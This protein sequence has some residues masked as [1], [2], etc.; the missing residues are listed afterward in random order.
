MGVQIHFVQSRCFLLPPC[1]M[2]W[3]IAISGNIILW[4][5][6]STLI[7]EGRFMKCG[8]VLCTLVC[9]KEHSIDVHA[10]KCFFETI[11]MPRRSLLGFLSHILC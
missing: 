1:M 10:T 7:C 11:C 4:V 2:D 5:S 8:A 3:K 6:G 9:V